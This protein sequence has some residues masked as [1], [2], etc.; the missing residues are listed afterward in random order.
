MK[1]KNVLLLLL[2]ALFAN[3]L[4]SKQLE[5]EATLR[6]IQIKATQRLSPR[7]M[8]ATSPITSLTTVSPVVYQLGESIAVD[9]AS[10]VT[11]AS[12]VVT[13]VQTGEVAHH[14]LVTCT[15]QTTILIDLQGCESGLYYINI[16]TSSTNYSGEFYL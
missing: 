13:N 16:V 2:F 5:T 7:S 12:I 14:E 6:E 8:G 9:F 3:N 11:N 10:A 1:A 4:N 15:T